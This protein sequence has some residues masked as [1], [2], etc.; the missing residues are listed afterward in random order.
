MEAQVESHLAGDTGGDPCEH[1]DADDHIGASRGLCEFST[2]GHHP[3]EEE[4]IRVPSSVVGENYAGLIF[5]HYAGG[6]EF[7]MDGDDFVLQQPARDDSHRVLS[8][9]SADMLYTLSLDGAFLEV[10]ES[11][12]KAQQGGALVFSYSDDERSVVERHRITDARD[13]WTRAYQTR[14]CSALGRGLGH[15]LRP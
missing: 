15:R 11:L 4:P 12:L 14:C 10:D 8:A 1:V 9:Y 3:L 5:I 6:D 7:C 2:T 13:A